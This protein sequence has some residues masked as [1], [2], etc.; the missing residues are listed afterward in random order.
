MINEPFNHDNLGFANMKC[1][2]KWSLCLCRLV[3][4]DIKKNV[5]RCSHSFTALTMSKLTMSA[6]HPA[7]YPFPYKRGRVPTVAFKCHNNAKSPI[8]SRCFG[9]SLLGYCRNLAV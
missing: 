7:E 8:L 4:V 6:L 5:F 2:R 9:L 1:H 3:F